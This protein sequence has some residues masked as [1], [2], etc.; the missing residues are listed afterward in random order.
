MNKTL[1]RIL[2]IFI[3]GF[4]I[5]NLVAMMHA[6]KFSNFTQEGSKTLG[7]SK[8]S[9]IQKIK[10][11]V[12]GVDNPKSKSLK[13][14]TAE[15]ETLFVLSDNQKIEIWKVPVQ[16]KKGWVVL[17][18]GYSASKSSLLAEAKAF[19]DLGYST[20]L[21]DFLGAGGSEGFNTT[22]GFKE[23]KQVRDVVMELQKGEASKPYLFGVSMGAVAILKSVSEYSLNVK[24]LI[25]ECPFG[26]ML[27]T[28]KARFKMMGV[29]S[30]P[31]AHLLTFWG[32]ALNGFNGF[33]HNPVGYASRVSVP[34]LHMLGDQDSKVSLL[35]SKEIFEAFLGAKKF[36]LFEELGHESYVTHDSL[37]W[38]AEMNAF[39]VAP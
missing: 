33:G 14:P 20:Y 9:V 8:L 35:E 24:G 6:Y 10:T 18:H 25:L 2:I 31:M 34:I 3:A 32:G 21:V 36:V 7:A 39:L 37:A 16:N 28:V 15:F 4:T 5:L 12:M 30:F 29:P 17:F 19:N 26:S 22:I 1:K 13:F 27:Q 11:L 23:A 38:V